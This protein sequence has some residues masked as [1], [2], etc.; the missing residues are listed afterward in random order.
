MNANPH[1]DVNLSRRSYAANVADH[2]Q[3]EL[4]AIPR[5]TSVFYRHAGNAV[6]AIAEK[7]DAKHVM[8]LAAE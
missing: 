2:P 8:F 3:A 4:H 5:V 7:L 6:I 1:V